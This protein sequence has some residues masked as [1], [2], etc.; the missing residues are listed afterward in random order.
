MNKDNLQHKKIQSYSTMYLVQHVIGT[1]CF[2]RV[3]QATDSVTAETVVIKVLNNTNTNSKV[4]RYFYLKELNLLNSLKSSPIRARY[5]DLK[6][7]FR[8]NTGEIC[9][10]MEKLGVTLHSALHNIGKL[11]TSICRLITRQIVQGM[12]DVC[13]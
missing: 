10:V 13:I 7:A 12:Y 3:Y 1:G 5:V 8:L 11:P 6:D 4:E 9:F 2:S